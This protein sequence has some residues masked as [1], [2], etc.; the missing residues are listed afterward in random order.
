MNCCIMNTAEVPPLFFAL[1]MDNTLQSVSQSNFNVPQKA[2]QGWTYA[3][4][5]IITGKSYQI[6]T[7]EIGT[8]VW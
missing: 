6:T 4:V 2:G 5:I 7:V 8:N 1:C 3:T